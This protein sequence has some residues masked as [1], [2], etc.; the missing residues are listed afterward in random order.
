MH[1]EAGQSAVVDFLKNNETL[2]YH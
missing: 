1:T 2:I